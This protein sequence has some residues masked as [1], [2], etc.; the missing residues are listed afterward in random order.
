MSLVDL[1]FGVILAILFAVIIF[2]F[3]FMLTQTKKGYLF[4]EKKND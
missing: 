4:G 3:I 1:G 2:W